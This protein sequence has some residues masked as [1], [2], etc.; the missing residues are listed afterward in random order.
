M[1]KPSRD[2]VSKCIIAFVHEDIKHVIKYNGIIRHLNTINKGN[3]IIFISEAFEI[4][5]KKLYSD[6]KDIHFEVVERVDMNSVSK[7]LLQSYKNYKQRQLFGLLDKFRLDKYKNQ[8]KIFNIN[9]FDPYLTYD[10]DE[11]L[12]YKDFFVPESDKTNDH[13]INNI[14]KFISLDYHL[15]SD[16]VHIPLNYRKA[17][18]VG[19]IITR[20]FNINSFLHCVILISKAKVIHL[21]D[22]H[23]FSIFVQMLKNSEAH[24]HIFK[25]NKIM[26][27]HKKPI[28]EQLDIP[29][30]WIKIKI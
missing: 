26:F 22:N 27:Y 16:D 12:R 23:F 7:L 29:R 28:P 30:E 14:R 24:S 15:F 3:L 13:I 11:C 20:M 9:T 5:F 25:S 8:C 6:I 21:S 19:I 17:G 4:F 1:S 10:F 18:S 2:F